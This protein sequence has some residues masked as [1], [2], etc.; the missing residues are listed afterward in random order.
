M[1]DLTRSDQ[2]R[3]GMGSGFRLSIGQLSQ[4]INKKFKYSNLNRK[5]GAFKSACKR[6]HGTCLHSGLT[7]SY[8]CLRLESYKKL[9][10]LGGKL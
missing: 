5:S 8:N 10:F 6:S 9:Q 1:P 4:F 3:S 7:E 2:T